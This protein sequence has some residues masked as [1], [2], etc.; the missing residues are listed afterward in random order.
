MFGSTT[1]GETVDPEE[2]RPRSPAGILARYFGQMKAIIES[3]D[4][5]VE[6]FIGDTVTAVFGVPRDFGATRSLTPR[7]RDGQLKFLLS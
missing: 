2:R 1:L 7:F 3:Y 5:S 6:K 4:G